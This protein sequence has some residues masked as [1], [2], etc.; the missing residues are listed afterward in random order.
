MRLCYYQII[1]ITF[2]KYSYKLL[3]KKRDN[4]LNKHRLALQDKLVLDYSIML[5]PEAK[6]LRLDTI[7]EEDQKEKYVRELIEALNTFKKC[8]HEHKRFACWELFLAAYPLC[9]TDVM[10][11]NRQKKVLA[12]VMKDLI[13][14]LDRCIVD[15]SWL[16]YDMGVENLKIRSGWQ[17]IFDQ[18]KDFKTG[19]NE[20][21]G[22][23]FV[24]LQEGLE[25]WDSALEMYKE[26][27]YPSF[28]GYK[29]KPDDFLRPPNVPKHHAWWK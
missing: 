2:H 25:F 16:N 11:G 7:I 6:R 19:S 17:Y 23:L 15:I 3:L 18:L 10:L 4:M 21:L 27:R 29:E 13:S 9:E 5:P 26:D 14:D 22:D 12:N 1:L 24:L 28:Y 8:S 20:T